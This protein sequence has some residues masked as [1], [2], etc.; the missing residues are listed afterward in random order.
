MNTTTTA[1]TTPA[2]PPTIYNRTFWLCYVANVLLV[3]AN[4]LTFRFAEFVAFLGGGEATAGA[5]VGVGM[6][7]AVISRFGIG[8]AID[9]YGTKLLWRASSV[10]M[11][12]SCVLFLAADNLH[13]SMYI[14]R[15]IFAVSMAC[16]FSCSM[17]YIQQIVPPRRRTEVIASLGSSG[18]VGMI[19]GPMMGDVMFNALPGGWTQFSVLFGTSASL[20]TV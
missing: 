5:I 14:V 8:Q 15:I 17:V 10:V 6:L 12:A 2:P 20:V 3:T 18:F 16:M 4:S 9:H 7:A 19:I 11:A 1:P 13:W